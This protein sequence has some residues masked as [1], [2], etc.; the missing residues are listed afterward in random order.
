MNRTT[1]SLPD[2]LASALKREARRRHTSVSSVAREALSD[3]FGLAGV[4]PREVPFAAIGRSTDGRN[5]AESEQILEE[6]FEERDRGRR[7]EPG[8]R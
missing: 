3:H 5:A 4:G 6:I 8:D 2:D 7:D 1:L